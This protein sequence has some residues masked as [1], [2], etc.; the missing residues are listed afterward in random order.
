MERMRGRSSLEKVVWNA[1]KSSVVK[2][3][4]AAPASGQRGL[5]FLRRELRR[6]AKHEVFEKMREAALA[7]LY[8]I[9]RSG[10][11][12]DEDRHD[13]GIVGRNRNQP[14]AIG[15]ILLNIRIGEDLSSAKK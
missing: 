14:E 8:L 7:G 5:V 10:S 1:V 11:Y 6:P 2:A 9:A 15:Q 12:D 3:L 13:V 4:D